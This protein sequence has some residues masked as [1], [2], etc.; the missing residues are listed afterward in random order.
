MRGYRDE[1]EYDMR[2]LSNMQYE[3]SN[4]HDF[5]LRVQIALASE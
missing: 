2:L 5:T 4:K 1:E 3:M